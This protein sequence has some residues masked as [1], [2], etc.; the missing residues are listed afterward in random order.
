MKR[1]HTLMIASGSQDQL[2]QG[3]FTPPKGKL[4]KG[5]ICKIAAPVKNATGGAVAGLSDAQK[6]ELLNCLEFTVTFG[7]SKYRKPYASERGPRI[8][9]EARFAYNSEIE[10]YSDATTGMGRNFANG[11]TT[12]ATFYL[13][14]PLGRMQC[15]L[16]D[17]RKLF[18]LGRTQCRTL[19]VE[20]KRVKDS[21]GT[22][23]LD[24]DP[25]QN[26]TIQLFPDYDSCQGD[27]HGL[28]PHWFR[29]T[30]T[31]DEINFSEDGLVLRV[32]EL[33][34][35]QL[36]CA[37]TNFD[38]KVDDEAY[39]E[40]LAIAEITRQLNDDDAVSTA[41]LLVDRETVLYQARYD[42]PLRFRPT[43]HVRFRQ[44]VKDIAQANI[45]VLFVPYDTEEQIKTE[46]QAT[47]D[48]FREKT[49][50]AANLFLQ[51][52]LSLPKRV[53]G[54]PFWQNFDLD[55]VEYERAPGWVATPG[56]T[57]PVLTVPESFLAVAT[58][59]AR[60]H[61][62][63]GETKALSNVQKETAALI[64][65]AIKGGRGTSAGFSPIINRISQLVK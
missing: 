59:K 7:A 35:I 9:R 10:G 40:G 63:A 57:E 25:A 61:E 17:E 46:V 23:N 65:G 41:G 21:L 33:S 44:N 18:G 13:P 52:G 20:V 31:N 47:A 30:E 8:H 58:S 64:P 49:V 42:E 2:R 51:T 1:I 37:L 26:L 6:Q 60:I 11:A 14:I 55:D 43:G 62:K 48:K 3:Q 27:V 29:R 38:L 22:A 36:A 54:L 53:Q 19:E 32:S 28:V 45:G 16:P 50:R 56:Q 4:L 34:A 5:L 24:I 15:V 12:T 39:A